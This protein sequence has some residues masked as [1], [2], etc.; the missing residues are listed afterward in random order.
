MYGPIAPVAISPSGALY[1]RVREW[2]MLEARRDMDGWVVD[3]AKHGNT[4]RLGRAERQ[5][6]EVMSKLN[7]RS[8]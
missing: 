3:D 7:C 4:I 1:F 6:A 8:T 5:E 2:R